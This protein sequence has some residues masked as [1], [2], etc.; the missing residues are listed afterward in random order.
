MS[1]ILRSVRRLVPN[2][3][4]QEMSSPRR[5]DKLPTPQYKSME[6]REK[7]PNRAKSMISR[8]RSFTS[9]SPRA[10]DPHYVE[11]TPRRQMSFRD[12]S[13]DVFSPTSP[14]SSSPLT[15]YRLME[16]EEEEQRQD[17]S[18]MAT[19]SPERIQQGLHRAQRRVSDSWKSLQGASKRLVTG[20]ATAAVNRPATTKHLLP[21]EHHAE[22]RQDVEETSHERRFLRKAVQTM[23]KNWVSQNSHLQ[24]Q[25]DDVAVLRSVRSTDGFIRHRRGAPPVVFTPSKDMVAA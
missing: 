8:A 14:S 3:E 22:S 18:P 7:K 4:E 11:T 1:N 12:A 16:E 25:N 21:N 20:R 19:T 10:N 9:R 13:S 24:Q 6:E 17:S 5:L 15:N 2:G 23:K